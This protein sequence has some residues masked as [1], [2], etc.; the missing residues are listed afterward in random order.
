[1]YHSRGKS[2]TEEREGKV[3]VKSF[4]ALLSDFLLTPKVNDFHVKF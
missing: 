1:M 3:E 2:L 4:Q